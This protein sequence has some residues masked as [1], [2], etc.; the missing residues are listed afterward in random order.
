MICLINNLMCSKD[1]DIL[2][3]PNNEDLCKHHGKEAWSQYKK[4]KESEMPIKEKVKKQS[5]PKTNAKIT[6]CEEI[7]SGG[8]TG[9]SFWPDRKFI[10]KFSLKQKYPLIEV[11]IIK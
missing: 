10:T 11:E 8:L 5:V 4:Q 1:G 2:P 3:G 6:G 7:V 9:R